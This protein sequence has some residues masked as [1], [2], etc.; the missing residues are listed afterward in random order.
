MVANSDLGVDYAL[1]NCLFINLLIHSL[2]N[3][4]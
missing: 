4:S 1:Q 2:K 3:T